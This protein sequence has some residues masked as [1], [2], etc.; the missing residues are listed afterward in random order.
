MP[1]LIKHPVSYF[2]HTKLQRTLTTFIAKKDLS[3]DKSFFIAL[4]NELINEM[5]VQH[6]I[7]KANY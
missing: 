2:N 3:A 5:R 1:V 4:Q 6:H 7:R